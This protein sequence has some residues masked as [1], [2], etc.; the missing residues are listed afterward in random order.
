MPKTC[1]RGK[2]LRKAFTRKAFTTKAGTRVKASRFPAT[3]IIDRGEP[4]KGRKHSPLR[5]RE[6]S[7]RGRRRCRPSRGATS[8]S[9]GQ[10]E[11]ALQPS[12]ERP[13]SCAT[14]RR[15]NLQGPRSGRMRTASGCDWEGSRSKAGSQMTSKVKGKKDERKR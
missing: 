15:T 1:P 4:G 11:K 12:S 14:S 13:P 6:A 10:R 9:A 2:I 5:S 7:A 8:S 3:C